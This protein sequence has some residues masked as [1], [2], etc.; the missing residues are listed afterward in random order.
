MRIRD[1]RGLG[2]RSEEQLKRIGITTADELRSVGAVAAFIALSEE[3][4]SKP[5]LNLLY[6][7]VGALEERDWRDVAR[8]DRASLLAALEG[9]RELQQLFDDAATDHVDSKRESAAPRPT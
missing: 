8:E 2:P 6:A 7:L 1:L 5:S 3:T 4:D 9:H